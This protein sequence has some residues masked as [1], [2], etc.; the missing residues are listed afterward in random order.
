M[1]SKSLSAMLTYPPMQLVICATL[2]NKS[3]LVTVPLVLAVLQVVGHATML[4]VN[5]VVPSPRNRSTS[6]I[7]LHNIPIMGLTCTITMPM[8]CSYSLA[9]RNANSLGKL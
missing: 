9:Q 5:A 7:T 1:R 3:A 6:S 2:P 4:P 8:R